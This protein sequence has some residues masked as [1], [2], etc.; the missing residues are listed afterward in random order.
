LDGRRRINQRAEKGSGL[1]RRDSHER[2]G[3]IEKED[4]TSEQ[5]I[6][7]QRKNIKGI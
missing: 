2:A 1:G 6:N 7:R 3:T 4:I 5:R